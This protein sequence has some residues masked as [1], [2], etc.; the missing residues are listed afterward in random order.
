[1]GLY[2]VDAVYVHSISCTVVCV[3]LCLL[4]HCSVPSLLGFYSCTVVC[5]RLCLLFRCSVPSLQEFCSVLE[6]KVLQKHCL[7]QI[8]SWP[9]FSLWGHF[10]VTHGHMSTGGALSAQTQEGQGQSDSRQSGSRHS[11]S[12]RVQSLAGKV[13]AKSVR[14][15]YKHID[16]VP[17]LLLSQLPTHS[18]RDLNH[19]LNC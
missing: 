17:P 15:E 11:A 13:F 5:V 18:V 3:H 8:Q 4:L 1:M 6:R 16:L 12:E 19:L 7:C 10:S 14:A 9:G 2:S